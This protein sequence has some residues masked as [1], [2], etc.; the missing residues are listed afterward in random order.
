MPPQ[1]P[2]PITFIALRAAA[3]SVDDIHRARLRAWVEDA[4]THR[5]QRADRP[6]PSDPL[7][8]MLDAAFVVLDVSEVAAFRTWLLKWCDYTGRLITPDEHERRLKS[9]RAKPIAQTR[10]DRR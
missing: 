9:I 2:P 5:G 6:E 1:A 7:L 3:L 4:F 8:R 10:L